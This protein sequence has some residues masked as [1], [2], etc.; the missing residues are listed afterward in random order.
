MKTKT[1][2]FSAITVLL[3]F[4][5]TTVNAQLC[6]REIFK[7]EGTVYSAGPANMHFIATSKNVEIKF[8]KTAGK[9]NA[10]LNIRYKRC[11][12]CPEQSERI[13]FDWDEALSTKTIRLTDVKDRRIVMQLVN[14]ASAVRSISYKITATGRTPHLFSLKDNDDNISKR[15]AHL[16]P[17]VQKTYYTV[18]SCKGKVKIIYMN[19]G[20]SA[21]AQFY[22]DE[23][24]GQYGWTPIDSEIISTGYFERVYESDKV[25]RIR[26]KNNSVGHGLRFGLEAVAVKDETTNTS[27]EKP[28]QTKVTKKK[29]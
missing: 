27:N 9:A 19:G 24:G 21:K 12:E 1:I 2:Q 5:S 17:Q 29:G 23:Q 18:P 25:L 28:L 11:A 15:G 4:F 3:L 8:K 7:R 26:I 20:G 6:L 13:A 22:I 14:N 16:Y 10:H